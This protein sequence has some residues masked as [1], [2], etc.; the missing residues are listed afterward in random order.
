MRKDK[1]CL[2]IMW[3]TH[4]NRIMVVGLLALS[5][6]PLL[7]IP[8]MCTH[9][10]PEPSDEY[11]SPYEEDQKTAQAMYNQGSKSAMLSLI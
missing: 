3:M 9:V 7:F 4:L 2:M 10:N 11:E 6:P 1:I 5:L 8:H